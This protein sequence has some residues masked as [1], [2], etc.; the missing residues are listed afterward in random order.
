MRDDVRLRFH[1]LTSPLHV[2]KHVSGEAAAAYCSVKAI[3]VTY[4][5]CL[6]DC[7]SYPSGDRFLY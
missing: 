5:N 4:E 1:C 7:R 6:A 2:Y 3:N